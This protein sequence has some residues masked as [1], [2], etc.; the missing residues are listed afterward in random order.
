MREVAGGEV[1]A[2]FLMHGKP[3][4]SDNL[5]DL[6]TNRPFGKVFDGLQ[7]YEAKLKEMFDSAP[8]EICE[9]PMQ[10]Y[11]PMNVR[12]QMVA[13]K[14]AGKTVTEIMAATGKSRPTILRTLNRLYFKTK[15]GT[16]KK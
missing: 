2:V 7:K 16:S 10:H 13:L 9:Q 3:V 8:A 11:T 1:A 6:Y 15:T 5:L 4:K 12:E 14:K